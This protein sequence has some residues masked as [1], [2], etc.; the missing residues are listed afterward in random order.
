MRRTVHLEIHR[1]DH[2]NDALGLVFLGAVDSDRAL[3]L[4]KAYL[5]PQAR[6]RQAELRDAVLHVEA[7][8]REFGEESQ[9]LVR[10]AREMQRAGRLKGAAGQWEEALRLSPLNPHA[11]KGLGRLHYRS[12]NV[13]IAKYYLTRARETAPDDGDVLRLLAEVALHD[14]QHLAARGYLEELV[15]RHPDDKRGRLSLARLL[16]EDARQIREELALDAPLAELDAGEPE[17]GA[18]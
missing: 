4:L 2:K 10:L 9:N 7:D 17:D 11:L 5:G 13:E 3:E 14:G 18:S 15:R 6:I 8:V 1:E 16:P 12:R